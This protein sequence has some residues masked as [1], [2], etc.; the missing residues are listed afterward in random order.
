MKQNKKTI[1]TQIH[2]TKGA[3]IDKKAVIYCRVSTKRQTKEGDEL[4]SQATRCREFA[5]YR[6]LEVI[7]VFQDSQ[8]GSLIDRPGMQAMLKYLRSHRRD[9]LTVIIDDL[10]RLAR[11]VEAHIHL[12]TAISSVGAKLASPSIEFGEDSD[13]VLVEHLLASVSQHHRQK[14]AEQTRNKKTSAY[15]EWLLGTFCADWL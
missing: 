3:G 5:R 4:A 13:S 11:G 8:S 12:R 10:S 9:N 1:E 7:E 15:A 6:N 14:N 2:K